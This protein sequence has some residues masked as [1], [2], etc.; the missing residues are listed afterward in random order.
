[1][2]CGVF[3]CIYLFYIYFVFGVRQR[4][5]IFQFGWIG[6]KIVIIIIFDQSFGLLVIVEFLKSENIE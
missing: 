3:S 2:I 5:E 6:Y 1:M 4:F